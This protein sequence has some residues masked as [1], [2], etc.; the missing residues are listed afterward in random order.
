MINKEVNPIENLIY[1]GGFTAIFR[2]IGCIGD[3]L[4]SG[5]H[6]SLTE[7]G[8][9]G[10]HDYYEYSWGQ[11]IARKCGLHAYNWSVGGLTAKQFHDLARYHKVFTPEK[12]CQ[13]YIIALGVNDISRVLEGVCE[14]GSL[15][16]VDFD[17]CEN[18]KDTVIGNYVKIIQ[19]I[20]ALQPK[21]KV[22]VTTMPISSNEDE[23]RLPYIEQFHKALRKLPELFEYLY[24]IDFN[25]YAP[26]YD[27]EFKKMYY[28]GGHLNAMGYKLTADM[29][30]TYIDYII[31]NNPDDFAQVAFIG[32]GVHNVSR[33]W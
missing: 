2:T 28:L 20:Y 22:F 4:S 15:D 19:R 33:K 6:E 21:A 31:K 13:A 29:Y 10:Y 5:E 14:L 30:M 32:K 3:S 16:D 1:D 7:D 25:K 11:F 23:K 24:V 12:A 27:A 26:I 17:N 9:K 8:V 18:N